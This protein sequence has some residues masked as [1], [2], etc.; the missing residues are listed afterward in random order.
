[1]RVRLPR[2]ALAAFGFPVNED[3]MEQAVK[4]DVVLGE[5]GLARAVRVV[6]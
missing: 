6:K 3:N 5:D 1:M 2:T 4:A